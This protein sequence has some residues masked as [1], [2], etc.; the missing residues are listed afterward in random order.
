MEVRRLREDEGA[1]LRDVRL[2]ALED[3][4][5][6]FSSWFQREAEYP[7][8]HWDDWAAR[9]NQVVYLAIEDGH[10]VGMAG[11]Y[12]P[13]DQPEAP[14]LWGMWVDSAA[15]GKGTGRQLVEA[16]I[17]WARDQGARELELSVTDGERSGPAAAL[18]R[19]L[20]FVTTGEREQLES[21]PQLTALVMSL[22]LRS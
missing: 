11:G 7:R 17:A 8:D 20:G 16:V 14:R 13:P 15:R 12:F 10:V 18:Y 21:D 6:A 5:Y 4:P 19:A 22:P 2:R 1:L 9:T 3:A